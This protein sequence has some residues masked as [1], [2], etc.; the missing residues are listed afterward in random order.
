MRIPIHDHVHAL[1]LLYAGEV[2]PRLT[3]EVLGTICL[4]YADGERCIPLQS[5]RNMGSLFSNYAAEVAQV[6][7]WG[8]SFVHDS[9][10]HACLGVDPDRLLEE[11]EITLDR[12]DAQLAL[13]AATVF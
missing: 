1:A 9:V 4:R 13:L 2:E 10:N 8:E 5:G 12:E 3:G 6:P 7:L 11:L